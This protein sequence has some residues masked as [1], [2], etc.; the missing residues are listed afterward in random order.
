MSRKGVLK[1]LMLILGIVLLILTVFEYLVWVFSLTIDPTL[2]YW[3]QMVYLVLIFV[4]LVLL[5]LSLNPES[6]KNDMS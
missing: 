3:I 4:F 1:E 2:S 6:P 5:F